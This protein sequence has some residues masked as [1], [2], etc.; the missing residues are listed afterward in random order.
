[1]SS[2]PTEAGSAEQVR[3]RAIRT[4]MTIPPVMGDLA[5]ILS[6]VDGQETARPGPVGTP[7]A[8]PA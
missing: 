1:M 6:F 2:T 7:S 3:M 8:R 5:D 4:K